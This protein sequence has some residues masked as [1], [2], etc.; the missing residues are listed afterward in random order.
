MRGIGQIDLMARSID[1]LGHL[2][3]DILK[4][5]VVKLGVE[6]LSTATLLCSKTASSIKTTSTEATSRRI[7]AAKATTS[8]SRSP[9]CS[10][11]PLI[12]R[13]SAQTLSLLLFAV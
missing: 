13:S 4:I 5:G 8:S 3:N 2:L 7:L 6:E 1:T 11:E 12:G 9:D 10:A